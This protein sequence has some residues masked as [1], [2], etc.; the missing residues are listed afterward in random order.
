MKFKNEKKKGNLTLSSHERSVIKLIYQTQKLKKKT[1]KDLLII[2]NDALFEPL[3]FRK[4][5]LRFQYKNVSSKI[6]LK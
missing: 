6:M 2:W 4:H 5:S 1:F 3:I